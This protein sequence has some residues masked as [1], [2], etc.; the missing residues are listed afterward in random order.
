V[1]R[2]HAPRLV[3][4]LHDNGVAAAVDIGHAVAVEDVAVRL[5]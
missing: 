4:A 3:D 1:P 5:M 2:D